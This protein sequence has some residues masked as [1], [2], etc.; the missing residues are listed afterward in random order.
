MIDASAEFPWDLK[1][2]L[3]KAGP[4]RHQLRGAARR[5]R[6]GRHWA[7]DPDRRIAHADATTSLIPITQILAIAANP[8]CGL[9]RAE[10]R[11][12]PRLATGEWLIAFALT[13]AAA[14][15]DVASNRMRAR[16]DGDCYVL[17]GSKRFIANGSVAN[18][19]T[20][21]PLTDPV[22]AAAG[23]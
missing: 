9:G 22:P 13:E 6:A 23:A 2:L 4:A 5:H 15:S 14:G 17:S 19:L 3:A 8:P 10:D 11:Y 7:V 12:I 20:C 1:E 21:L 18:V 16:L